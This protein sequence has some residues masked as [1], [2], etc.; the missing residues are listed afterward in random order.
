MICRR[1][2]SGGLTFALA[3]ISLLAVCPAFAIDWFD[4]RGIPAP[5]PDRIYVCHSYT[6]RMASPIRFS[7]GDLAILTEPLAKPAANPAAE[8]AAVGK[9]E[10]MFEVIVG[11]RIGTS[12]DLP[13]MQF[14]QGNAGQLDC[15]DEA[16][17]T[18]SLLRLLDAHGLLHHHRVLQPVARGFFVDLRYPHATAVLQEVESGIK[19]AIDSWPRANAEPPV[20]QL[21][22]EWRRAGPHDPLPTPDS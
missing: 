13:K 12:G 5:E 14:G 9:V 4:Q 7:E 17:N 19:W 21:L 3:A 18:T 8:R 20:I 6:C 2:P 11:K 10:Q 15:I 22:S 16:T 1:T